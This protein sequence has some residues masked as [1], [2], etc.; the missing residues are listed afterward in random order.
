MLQRY[1]SNLRLYEHK[2]GARLGLKEE[3][4]ALRRW[5]AKCAG[6]L[7]A[8]RSLAFGCMSSGR[9]GLPL[10]ERLSAQLCAVPP[11]G[12]PAT[13]KGDDVL[14]RCSAHPFSASY[15]V[16]PES[17][18]RTGSMRP[19]RHAQ[20]AP[21]QRPAWRAKI[22]AMTLWKPSSGSLRSCP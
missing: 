7:R 20:A 18:M 17:C 5:R 19:R 3:L 10:L 2:P 21:S 16:E 8:V 15:P 4:H 12:L 13:V 14:C 9:T 22:T 6:P 11:R 1:D